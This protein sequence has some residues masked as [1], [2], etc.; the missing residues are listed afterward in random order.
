MPG[1]S[2]DL[3][4]ILKVKEFQTSDD[5]S[6]DVVFTIF[7]EPREPA[8]GSSSPSLFERVVSFVVENWQPSPVMTHVWS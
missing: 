3:E 2:V 8:P 4:R 7:L 5:G 6:G 1:L